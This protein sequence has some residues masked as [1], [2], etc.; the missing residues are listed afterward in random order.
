[1]L[2]TSNY[3]VESWKRQCRIDN[4]SEQ[5]ENLNVQLH[6]KVQIVKLQCRMLK[7]QGKFKSWILAD[8]ERHTEQSPIWSYFQLIALY[9][10]STSWSCWSVAIHTIVLRRVC[11]NS[12]RWAE[13]DFLP[14]GDEGQRFRETKLAGQDRKYRWSRLVIR[15]Q[16]LLYAASVLR[17]T[18]SLITDVDQKGL[19]CNKP[20]SIY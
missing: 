7:I 5:I 20:L 14:K 10:C 18:L 11:W 6:M 9:K 2:N 4:R 16:L 19:R 12:E 1:M 17:M 8:I 3:K 15:P 13:N